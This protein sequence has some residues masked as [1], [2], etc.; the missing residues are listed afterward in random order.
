MFC[1]LSI[2]VC[3]DPF[4]CFG[5]TLPG[6]CVC[7]RERNA[8]VRCLIWYLTTGK[9]VFIGRAANLPLLKSRLTVC[10]FTFLRAR[11]K[12]ILKCW[13]TVVE[14]AF[15]E[16]WVHICVAVIFLKCAVRICRCVSVRLGNTVAADCVLSAL[17]LDYPTDGVRLWLETDSLMNGQEM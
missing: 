4:V 11:R 3:Y 12:E 13:Q 1:C 10:V 15:W 14:D 7:V 17:T 9:Q 6:I 2:S 5:L 8:C 16:L